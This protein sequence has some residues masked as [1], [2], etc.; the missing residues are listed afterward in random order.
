MVP[1]QVLMVPFQTGD[2]RRAPCCPSPGRDAGPHSCLSPLPS[3][4]SNPEARS[5]VGDRKQGAG[6]SRP[7]ARRRS[8]GIPT[9]QPSLPMPV[10][11]AMDE[12]VLSRSCLLFV[13]VKRGV[14]GGECAS[15]TK[16]GE[17]ANSVQAIPDS[18]TPYP[19]NKILNISSAQIPATHPPQAL[20]QL[21]TLVSLALPY[22]ATQLANTD[23]SGEPKLGE[24]SEKPTDTHL[25]LNLGKSG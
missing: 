3:P 5:M 11:H 9:F 8:S 25:P 16:K 13:W 1:S 24:S 10:R 12:H 22:N 19:P 17:Q 4:R 21:P 20:H 15:A 18:R 7:R 14:W 23:E 2:R 6:G